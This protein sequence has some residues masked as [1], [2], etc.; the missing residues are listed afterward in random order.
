MP[1]MPPDTRKWWTV[2]AMA[3]PLLLLT[4]DFFGITVALPTIGARLGANANVLEWTVNAY[5][6]GFA[7]PLT[8]VGRLGDI[9]GRRRVLLLGSLLFALASAGCGLAQGDW[10]LI[11]GRA[12]Q[13]I[14]SAMI[15]STSLSI[16]S[17]AFSAEQRG[18]G[19]GLWTA[20]G[21][22]G[23]AIGPLV[24]G[25]L[26]EQ[27]SWRWFFFVNI[28]VAAIGIALALLVVEESR[29][30]SAGHKV[31]LPGFVLVT[32]GLVFLVLGFQLSNSLTFGSPLVIASLVAAVI[33]LIGFA[34]VERRSAEP[35]LQ[36]ELFNSRD[37][38]GAS[39]VAFLA[40]YGFG[41]CT[42]FVTL[43]LQ[44]VLEYTP[45][46]TGLVFLALSIPFMAMSL[47]VG[48]IQERWGARRPMAAGMGL[49]AVSFL[50]M[51]F[52]SPAAGVGFVIAGLIV[53]SIGQGLAYNI[54]TTAGMSAI[55]E[56]KAGA[57]SGVLCTIRLLGL[58]LG[59]AATGALF[60]IL[61]TSRL[62]S[63][64]VE[65]G[66]SLT[67]ANRAEIRGLLSGTHGA[68]A[69]LAEI[70][71]ARAERME[72]IVGEAFVYARVGGLGLT[73]ALALAGIATSFLVRRD[74]AGGAPRPADATV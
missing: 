16:V 44:D 8:A 57:A 68:R 66:A 32:A 70:A 51:M 3:F 26:T 41:V 63:L 29:D 5:A 4:I 21:L 60:K 53:T 49:I 35:L 73:V 17:N 55:P 18:A 30:D 13:G 47:I 7:A 59:V 65:A 27:L 52:V 58:V 43:Y 20:I 9:I 14:G 56:Q 67:D 2:V 71:P 1:R 74:D 15:Y 11:A 25:V 62:H 50:V 54:S 28:P 23:S 61:E 39:A 72:G 31:D 69:K 38:L 10:S 40:N 64:L 6:L 36:F 12:V 46:Q 42:F 34:L 19:I 37:Y 45:D 24:G 22:I 33:L 48:R